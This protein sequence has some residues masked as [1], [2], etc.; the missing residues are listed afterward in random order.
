M[1][2]GLSNDW[3][4]PYHLY[5]FHSRCSRGSVALSAHLGGF[6]VACNWS[7][8]SPAVLCNQELLPGTFRGW[9]LRATAHLGS[10]L[11]FRTA[12]GNAAGQSDWAG[13]VRGAGRLCKKQKWFEARPHVLA[14]QVGVEPTTFDFGD[15]RAASCATDTCMQKAPAIACRGFRMLFLRLADQLN[16][17]AATCGLGH[18]LLKGSPVAT[19]Y[20]LSFNQKDSD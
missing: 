15:R 12:G 6:Q 2:I 1:P 16:W 14:Y 7:G 11:I 17:L 4:L 10:A 3:A 8:L 5:R 18:A 20:S 13:W 19:H 9:L